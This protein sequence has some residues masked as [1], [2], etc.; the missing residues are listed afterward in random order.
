MANPD[1]EEIAKTLFALPGL[2]DCNVDTSSQPNI[3]KVS[4]R[5]NGTPLRD[6]I[7]A[8]KD[9]GYPT[10]KLVP[11]AEENS[12]RQILEEEVKRYR[13][14][15]LIALIIEIPILILMWVTPY[16]NP[17]FLSSHFIVNGMP[18]YIFILLALSTVIQFW[19]GAPFYKGA[20][21]ALKG[22]SANMDV[23]VVLGTTA[24]WLYGVILI[25]IGDHAYGAGH[26]ETV[27]SHIR[28]SVHEHGHNFEIAS[29]LIVVILFGKFLESVTKKQTVDKLQQLA[30]L[31]VSTATLVKEDGNLGDQG[32]EISIELLVVGDVI[33]V[34]NG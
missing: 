31:K 14:K 3:V 1:T 24:A 13:R 10:A 5:S 30:S 18:L 9:L 12:I 2:V 17:E 21:K 27:E 6:I 29:T 34:I 28:H 11:A 23:L 4:Y 19:I 15:F 20:Y 22:R 16:T 7:Q 25:F 8:V 32:T 26:H 33:K